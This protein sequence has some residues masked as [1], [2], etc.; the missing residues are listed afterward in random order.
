MAGTIESTPEKRN[1]LKG[2]PDNPA[3]DPKKRPKDGKG[4][5]GDV[6]LQDAIIVVAVCWALLILLYISLRNYNI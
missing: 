1:D 3:R 4:S 6:A 5:I 2:M